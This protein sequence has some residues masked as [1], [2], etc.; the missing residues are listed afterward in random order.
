MSM[1]TGG[2]AP[3]FVAAM[4]TFGPVQTME[5]TAH[6]DLFRFWAWGRTYRPNLRPMRN[7]VGFRLRTCTSVE[8]SLD[9]KTRLELSFADLRN[10]DL[11]VT[12][13]IDDLLAV[14]MGIL[15]TSRVNE[16]AVSLSILEN[17]VD[18]HG[19]NLRGA[20]LHTADLSAAHLGGA[21]LTLADLHGA[22]LR[23]TDL[24]RADLSHADLGGADLS[25]ADLR[26][27]KLDSAVLSDTDL[28]RT[29]LDGQAQLDQACG[30]NI[31]PPEG[32]HLPKPCPE[33]GVLGAMMRLVL[34]SEPA[35]AFPDG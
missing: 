26:S 33:G 32:L 18:L 5:A 19:A 22:N 24:S 4:K 11:G 25:S 23:G 9:G 16:S 28:S 8:C 29:K 27:A 12:H 20:N 34:E 35:R 7:W 31:K 13:L 15:S 21:N 6:P 2:K 1:V 30:T 3:D 14:I 10:A 17:I